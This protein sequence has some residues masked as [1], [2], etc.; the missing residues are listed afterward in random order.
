MALAAVWE[1]G[2]RRVTRLVAEWGAVDVW[3]QLRS[4]RSQSAL[5]R[6]ARAADPNQLQR[7]T[8]LSGSRFIVPGDDDWPEG[9]DDLD[10]TGDEGG[11]T[12]V[13]LWLAGPGSLTAIAQGGVAVVGSRA[14]TA[15]GEHV[16]ADLAVGL[17]EA[18]RAV[19]SGGAYGIDAA[20]HRGALA[21]DGVTVAFMAGGLSRL[22]PAGNTE[23]LRRIRDHHLLVS[24]QPPDRPPSRPSFLARN[25]LIAA[26]ARGSVVV[27]GGVRSGAAN[28]ARWT[29]SLN[30]PLAAVPG[31][32]TSAS[33]FT[34]HRLIRDGAAV[35]VASAD[36]VIALL[37]PFAAEREPVS[38]TVE[39]P[40]DHLP[41]P[42]RAV[43]E[44]LPR[45][46]RASADDL[47]GR[48]GLSLTQVLL[49]LSRLQESDLAETG[50]GGGYRATR[51]QVAT[52]PDPQAALPL[53]AVS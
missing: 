27:E 25:R 35:L 17:A 52:E 43:Y 28:T 32:V 1:A 44:A 9:L 40:L 34:P 6:R 51:R 36:D 20:A 45:R 37:E 13:G 48:T 19:L 49:A 5:A 30:R 3:R 41:A 14:A 42:D 2:D 7:Q 53:R 12:P 29:L 50:P 38:A 16:A 11:G 21:V 23:L 22:Y 8:E 15:Y 18:G 47:A 46:G 31:P 10:Q 4:D 39:S 24:E 26:C 33:S